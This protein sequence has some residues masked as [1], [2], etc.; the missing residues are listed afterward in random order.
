[1]LLQVP[2]VLIGILIIALAFALAVVGVLLVH[3]QVPIEVRKSYS[4]GLGQIRGSLA[5]MFAII[6]GFAAFLTLN[7]YHGA[8][9]TV[10]SEAENVHEIYTLAQAL[11]QPK[12][13]QIQGLAI[14]YA[15]VVI[16]EEWPLRR[17]GRTSQRAHDIADEL[18][19]SIQDG[20][21][22]SS[23]AQQGIYGELLSVMNQ[24]DEDRDTRLIVRT[25]LPLILWV[26]L[27][28]LGTII[29]GFA[30]MADIENRRIHLLTVCS[31]ATSIAVVFFT[32]F[33]LDYPFRTDINPVG[34]QPFESVLHE[35]EGND[36]R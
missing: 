30:A 14:S 1:M 20:Y 15:R 7:N 24:L 13:E 32:I 23:D 4:T 2:T 33:V 3:R 16:E 10:Q 9:L 26:A 11:P 27:V 34:P 25:D 22:T 31:L 8:Q 5:A 6:V 17:E 28:V 21:T 35:M 19:T 29:V 18:R 36:T 12:R